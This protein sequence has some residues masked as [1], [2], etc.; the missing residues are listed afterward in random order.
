[1]TEFLLEINT[2]EM[3]SSHVKAGLGE[4]KEKI[5]AELA[6]RRIAV[7]ALATAGTCRRLVVRGEFAP[8]QED[9]EEV[10]I[11]PPKTAAFGP[12]GAPTPAAR[13][14]AK[15]Q[16]A[17]VEGL[18]VIDTPKGQYVGLARKIFGQPTAEVLAAAL[19]GII[20]SLSFPKMM[21]WGESSLRFSRPIKRI[22]CL[23]GGKVLH[24][25]V[26]EIASSDRTSGHRL[27]APRKFKIKGREGE[28]LFQAYERLLRERRVI[29]CPEERKRAILDQAA[30][31]LEPLGAE[32]YPDQELLEKLSYDVECPHVILGEFPAEYLELPLEVLSMAM[33]EG[34]KLFSVVKGGAQLANFLGVTDTPGDPKSLIRGG[35]ERVLKARLEDAR[36]F[37]RQDRQAPLAERG[38]GLENVVFQERL[39]SYAHKTERLKELVAYLCD[40][41]GQGGLKK[42]AVEAAG[43]AKVDLITEMV[44]EFPALQGKMGGLYAKA[45]GYP[46]AVW[47]A[48]Y[49]HYLPLSF[50]GPAPSTMAGALLSLADKLDS[51]VGIIGAGEQV[52]GSSDPFGLRRSAHGVGRIIL[53]R[54]LSLPFL[55]V[56]EKAA[57]RYVLDLRLNLETGK[58]IKTCLAFFEQRLRYIFE[59]QG[60]R[61]DLINAVLAVGL[62][63]IY[64]S[65][66]RLRALN[67]IQKSPDFSSLILMAKRVNNILR[68]IQPREVSPELFQEPEERALF[69]ALAGVEGEVDGKIAGGD[70]AGAQDAIL[71]L[72]APLSLFFEK[73]LV[74]A[75]DAAV[76]GNR[77]AILQ[78]I[79]KVLLKLADYSLV[80]VEGEKPA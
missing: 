31:R 12:D 76:R 61:Y 74:M 45:E 8:R 34:Q 68:G 22:L 29:I 58:I 16:S 49:E 73:V 72:R 75:E 47:R 35:N 65:L 17:E 55:E 5:G 25:S 21:R 44:R 27:H 32:P 67:A 41:L 51:I 43:L 69:A 37:W 78:A 19:P 59:T 79:R 33:R 10:V 1:M 36:F 26:G 52:T 23:F 9:R 70:F 11:G 13:G 7:E 56:L 63:N 50:E 4:L 80:V 62:D 30:R 40:A 53:E 15:S 39:G 77:L 57:G 71:T 64:H 18:G 6:D 3:P 42:D 66:L 38:P 46:E 2:E 54:G 24:F 48:V 28:T 60:Y 20:T 14:F